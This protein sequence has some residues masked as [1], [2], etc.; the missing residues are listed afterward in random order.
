MK[1]YLVLCFMWLLVLV[2]AY[3]A[4]E[5]KTVSDPVTDII[6]TEGVTQTAVEKINKLDNTEAWL[7]DDEDMAIM[8]SGIVSDEK[9]TS[10]ILETRFYV[11]HDG[12][13]DKVGV[14]RRKS[15]YS[16]HSTSTGQ[17]Y[18]SW[19]TPGGWYYYYRE[20][21]FYINSSS[22]KLYNTAAYK[23]KSQTKLTYTWGSTHGVFTG[24]AYYEAPANK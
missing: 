10:K 2:P 8:D 9:S 1:K 23:A 6:S 3:S 16:K 20:D 22:Y 15:S 5:V 18:Y 21:G 11:W 7:I 19:N 13:K 17:P 4:S 14:V 24:S 12:Y